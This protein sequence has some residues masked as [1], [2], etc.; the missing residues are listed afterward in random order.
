MWRREGL[1]LQRWLQ[2]KDVMLLGRPSAMAAGRQLFP[3]CVGG[4]PG[5]GYLGLLQ[6]RAWEA[7]EGQQGSRSRDGQVSPDRAAEGREQRQQD[8]LEMAVV[9]SLAAIL[10]CHRVE[11]R[12]GASG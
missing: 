11:V 10:E 2:I 12:S 7:E 9:A 3:A 1:H 4:P 6:G 5:R 8:E